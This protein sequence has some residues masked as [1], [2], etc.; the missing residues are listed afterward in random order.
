MLRGAVLRTGPPVRT[1]RGV[2]NTAAPVQRDS[3]GAAA[4]PACEET[5]YLAGYRCGERV[6]V[7]TVEDSTAYV[8]VLHRSL[9]SPKR[10]VAV[11]QRPGRG[12]G[13]VQSTHEGDL[14]RKVSRIAWIEV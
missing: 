12:A 11:W 5:A 8:H 2:V 3:C 14:L 13:R 9:R 7:Q 1:V 10:S 6:R 4:S